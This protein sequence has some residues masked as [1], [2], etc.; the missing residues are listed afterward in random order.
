MKCQMTMDAN[1]LPFK[2]LAD[3]LLLLPLSFFLSVNMRFLCWGQIFLDTSTWG[4]VEGPD[5]A[6]LEGTV[7]FCMCHGWAWFP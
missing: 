3:V 7:F 2:S 6:Q 1:R 4:L 5:V